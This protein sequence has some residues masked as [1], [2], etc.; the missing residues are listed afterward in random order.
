MRST[1]LLF[2][3]SFFIISAIQAQDFRN[4]L[5]IPY[6]LTGDTIQLQVQ[7]S[8]HNFDPEGT[9]ENVDLDTLLPT[10]C[11]NSPGNNAM[12]YL[13]PTLFWEKGSVVQMLINNQLLTDSCTVHWHGLNIPSHVDGG[14]HQSF[15]AGTSWNPALPIID[16][17]QTLWYHSHLMNFT[18]EQV[19]RGQAGMIIIEDKEKDPYRQ[20]LPHDYG[21]NDI[22]LVI[23]EKGFNY[24]TIGNELKA[25][26]LIVSEKPGNGPFTL[27]N[28]VVNSIVHVPKE[29]IRFR[30]LNG[31]PRKAFQMG[32]SPT[33]SDPQSDEF[34]SIY[35]FG[36]DGGYMQRP[37]SLDSFLLSVGERKEMLLDLSSATHGDTLYLSNL[38]RSIPGDIITG[39]RN[40][41]IN[42]PGDAFLA[43]VVDSDLH[44]P[45]PIFSIPSMLQTYSVDTSDIFRS[46]TKRLMGKAGSGDLWTIDGEPMR[47]DK[48]NDTILVNSKEK[49]TIMNTTDIAH[50]F[51]IHKVQFQV[52][53]Y[54]GNAGVDSG[55][56]K[57]YT[58]PDL[59]NEM[60]GF[61]DD[62][63]IRAGARLT[64][65]AE[66]DT[67]PDNEIK[68]SNGY[69]YHCHILTHEDNS[70]MHQ[71]TVVDSA[72]YF[73]GGTSTS[74]VLAAPL[75][76]YPNPVQDQLQLEGSVE[77][78]LE[79][80]FYDL[81]GRDVGSR[82]LHFV[83][84]N[85][86][87]DLSGF[88]KGVLF[89][90]Y[91]VKGNRFTEKLI[92]L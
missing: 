83:Q 20:M 47:M 79:L 4:P 9:V 80:R 30:F 72:T 50:P 68:A 58:Y 23:Q 91:Y 52:I 15:A 31:S 78:P 69:M 41:E 77:G 19:I 5:P 35:Q 42:T 74:Q 86:T 51:H 76:V 67:F 13:G 63:L 36:T 22:P 62:I 18:T 24:D 89:M 6:S 37:Y 53:E 38:V 26:G 25:T 8:L 84:G 12:S 48:L 21:I 71:F 49:W 10:N 44:S 70:M 39:G 66:F 46:R 16:S 14:P 55:N 32:V 43:I 29:V 57:L 54:E 60:L 64:F 85:F 92:K 59:P 1:L 34:V 75:K 87:I 17:V 88:P 7:E 11:Y 3:I 90:T 73:D 28:G 65:I 40:P 27:I 2:C 82:K 45:D 56:E 81:C 61:K 33:L